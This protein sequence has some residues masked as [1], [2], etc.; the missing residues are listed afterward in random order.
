MVGSEPG[1]QSPHGNV[2]E[3]ESPPT[4]LSTPIPASPQLSPYAILPLLISLCV[5]SRNSHPHLSDTTKRCLP[6]F[7]PLGIVVVKMVQ[8]LSGQ[9][10]KK[11]SDK[12]G[13]PIWIPF[14]QGA[15]GKIGI[16]NYFCCKK[17]EKRIIAPDFPIFYPQRDAILVCFSSFSD[18]GVWCYSI[19]RCFHRG[20]ARLSRLSPHDS[21]GL[22]GA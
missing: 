12:E 19:Q 6:C 15:G 18:F 1:G 3:T 5:I 2:T 8:V 14:L 22:G 17:V 13:T 10:R 9:K 20:W 4:G 16:K 21:T 11:T 7:I